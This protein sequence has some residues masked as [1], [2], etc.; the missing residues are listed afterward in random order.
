[1]LRHEQQST[2]MALAAALHHSSGKVHAEREWLLMMR[3]NMSKDDLAFLRELGS[4]EESRGS[5]EGAVQLGV[6]VHSV[7][8]DTATP[9]G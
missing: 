5:D 3:G 9:L 7:V 6:N 8:T 2:R 4:P 1:M